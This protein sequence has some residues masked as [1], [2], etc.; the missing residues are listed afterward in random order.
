M[1]SYTPKINSPQQFLLCT[2]V[3][4]VVVLTQQNHSIVHHNGKSVVQQIQTLM[5]TR[6]IHVEHVLDMSA[7]SFLNCFRRF[8]SRRG[9][10]DLII[11]DNATQFKLAAGTLQL[12]STDIV[13]ENNKFAESGFKK[14]K[15]FKEVYKSSIHWLQ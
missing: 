13:Q 7:F 9:R 5:F 2:T 3:F 14:S 15:P 8:V 11:S 10:S 4:S 6:A 12:A 1:N